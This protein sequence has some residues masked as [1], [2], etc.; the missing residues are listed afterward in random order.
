MNVLVFTGLFPNNIFPHQ[1]IFIKE[2]MRVFSQ[3]D[4]VSVRVVAP[5]PYYPPIGLG[6]RSKYSQVAK[7]E[8]ID[9]LEVTHPRYLMTPRIGMVFYGTLLA[10]S[11]LPHLKR[12]QRTFD[13]DLIDSHFLYPDGFAAVLL[14][15]FLGKPVTVSARGSDVNIYKDLPF[16]PPLLKYALRRSGHVVAV[17]QA[18]A[19]TIKRLGV[20]GDH[21]SVIPNG[22]DCSK[23]FPQSREA[24][25]ASLGLASEKVVLSIGHLTWNK[26]FDLLIRA[27]K[28]VLESLKSK[29]IQLVI[30]GDGAIRTALEALTESL[31]LTRYVRFVGAVPN[32]ELRAWYN[33]ADVFCLASKDEGWPNVLM[34][35][36]ACG[37]PIVA[38]RV[39]GIPEIVHSPHL[40]LLTERAPEAF[41]ATIQEALDRTWD[42]EA[43]ALDAGRYGWDHAAQ[44][45]LKMFRSVIEQHDRTYS[46]RLARQVGPGQPGGTV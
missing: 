40:G 45:L 17:S 41:A 16:I 14:G 8:I 36:L 29:S 24:A 2:R 10:L 31:G 13:F 18:L 42:R 34:E 15:N 9:G 23:F 37:T 28:L 19:N 38:T 43:I 33:A 4:G 35:A 22:V 32:H 39:G 21:I 20:S 1:G 6:R 3:L 46:P 44:S 12:I 30:L 25:R 27:M 5:V 7:T 26:G 11:V